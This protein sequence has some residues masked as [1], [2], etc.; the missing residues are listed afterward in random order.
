ML[1]VLIIVQ[2]FKIHNIEN[3]YEDKIST[4]IDSAYYKTIYIKRHIVIDYNTLKC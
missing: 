2:F 3:Y 4:S 1:Y